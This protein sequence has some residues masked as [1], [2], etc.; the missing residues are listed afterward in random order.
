MRSVC[1][2]LNTICSSCIAARDEKTPDNVMDEFKSKTECVYME[3]LMKAP[4][5]KGQALFFLLLNIKNRESKNSNIKNKGKRI[6]GP[7]LSN[8]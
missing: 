4:L 1:L 2:I 5:T 8:G 6:S 7:M 3:D